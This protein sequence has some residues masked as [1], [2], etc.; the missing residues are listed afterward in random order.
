MNNQLKEDLK[1]LGINKYQ[2]LTVKLVTAKYKKLAK[3]KHPDKEGGTT[4]DFQALQ[5]AY[6]RVIN[7]IEEESDFQ[8]TEQNFEK[9][10]FMKNNCMKECTSRFVVYI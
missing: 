8:E 1:T 7:F 6:K 3:E 2:D 9:E 5:N 10:F 4:C